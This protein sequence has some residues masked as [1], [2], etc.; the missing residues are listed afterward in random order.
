MSPDH[1]DARP[2]E[3]ADRI[4]RPRMTVLR[5][6]EALR[7]LN[8]LDCDIQ[9]MMQGGREVT[10]TYYNLALALDRDLLLSMR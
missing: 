5:E 9:E 6:L 8:V 3:V 4:A 2:R 10:L 7:M 1:P